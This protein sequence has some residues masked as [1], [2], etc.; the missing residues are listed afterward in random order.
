[1]ARNVP[2]Y[3][4]F[5]ENEIWPSPEPFHHETISARSALHDWEIRP[6]SHGDL[7]QV[8][9]LR[10]GSAEMELE[11]DRRE[12]VTPCILSVPPGRVH[13]FRFV[14]GIDGAIVSLPGFLVDRL[15]GDDAAIR[16]EL[17]A[18]MYRELKRGDPEFAQFSGYFDEFAAEY[19]GHEPG[20][21][22]LLTSLLRLVLIRLARSG[23][24]GHVAAAPS[25]RYRRRL[26]R[27]VAMIDSYYREHRPVTFYAERLGVTAAQLNNTC[28]RETGKSAK[29]LVHERLLLEARR[30]LV[31]SDLDITAIGLALGFADSAYFTRFFNR[32]QGMTPSRF[33]LVKHSG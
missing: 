10:S 11:T 9:F 26:E 31:Y 23:R 28:R 1:M 6:H 4:L 13:G 24:P 14:P 29:Q 20:R 3:K 27:F 17:A 16:A 33:R 12:L 15:T 21:L 32:L 22:N 7:L 30:L 5:G 18:P 2:T 25:D 8:L 19:A